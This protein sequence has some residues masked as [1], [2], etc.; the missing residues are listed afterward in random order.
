[1]IYDVESGGTKARVMALSVWGAG[2]RFIRKCNPK[3]LGSIMSV[4][5]IFE[6]EE[7][8]ISTESLLES[9]GMKVKKAVKK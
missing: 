3:S 1:M 4:K 2:K 6:K 9:M 7:R 8:Y 5:S